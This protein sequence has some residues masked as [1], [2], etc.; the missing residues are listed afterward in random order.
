MIREIGRGLGAGWVP[1]DRLLERRSS[2]RAGAYSP[3]RA[4]APRRARRRP[5]RRR[6]QGHPDHQLRSHLGA[7]LLPVAAPSGRRTPT[8]PSRFYAIR[9]RRARTT[10]ARL[11]RF[12]ARPLQ[13]PS[14]GARVLERAQPLVLP[15][16]AA[17]R[18]RRLLRARACTCACCK[19]FHAGVRAPARACA[20]SPAPPPPSG[21]TT[22]T[23]RARSA[24][25]AS[26]AAA[27]AGRY[28]DVYSHHPYTPGGSLYPAPGQPPND[29]IHH[30]D[31]RQ[32]AHAA[33]AL[34]AQAL[35]PHRVRLRHAPVRGARR[36]RRLG[37]GAGPLPAPGVS[38]R[39]ELP[40]GQA[41]GVVPAA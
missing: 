16:S 12:L 22:S 37:G 29:P 28:F 31:A 5:A 3:S 8:G 6:R 4:R 13:G 20:S 24:S 15:L 40:S 36:V 1:H 10:T 26:C 34:P 33:P 7:G 41:A 35:L 23:A 27:D 32:P 14:P 18:R 2:R 25:R 38:R 17:H 9:E 21:S 11:G 19:A 30:R 39:G